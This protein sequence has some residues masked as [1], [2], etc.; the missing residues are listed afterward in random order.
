MEEKFFYSS[1]ILGDCHPWTCLMR[2]LSECA[3]FHLPG[4]HTSQCAE[5]F[6]PIDL[7][8][9][10]LELLLLDCDQLQ[11]SCRHQSWIN[12][13]LVE[14]LIRVRRLMALTR[15]FA[16]FERFCMQGSWLTMT[17]VLK[18]PSRPI[19]SKVGSFSRLYRHCRGALTLRGPSLVDQHCDGWQTSC[20][21]HTSSLPPCGFASSS[22]SWPMRSLSSCLFE[23][24][25]C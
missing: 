2:G 13:R 11:K 19:Q 7:D 18:M 16:C 10:L 24:S 4:S 17:S 23:G 22:K 25:L 20:T 12:Y 21:V 5:Y 15:I 9:L 8:T 3:S 1:L 6:C 14:W